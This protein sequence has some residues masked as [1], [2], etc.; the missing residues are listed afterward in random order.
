MTPSLSMCAIS[1]QF[2]TVLGT[3]WHVT[4][5]IALALVC[6][7]RCMICPRIMCVCCTE[8]AS[9]HITCHTCASCML[10]RVLRPVSP[11]LSHDVILDSV[12]PSLSMRAHCIQCIP[13]CASLH[14]F[15][16]S[17]IMCV[18]RILC[19]FMHIT[20]HTCVPIA[21]CDVCRDQ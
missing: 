20:C 17:S 13:L 3:S 16:L 15:E 18:C 10:R 2:L 21:C 19:A 12:T 11:L 9:M 1:G 4:R 6:L 14:V 5:S 7:F 8:C